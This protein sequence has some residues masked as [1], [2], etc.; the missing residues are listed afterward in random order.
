MDYQIQIKELL[1]RLHLQLKFAVTLQP[2]IQLLNNLILQT[3]DFLDLF[4]QSNSMK[5]ITQYL[6]DALKSIQPNEEL[7]YKILT[8]ILRMN[9]SE[10]I[11]RESEIAK[12]LLKIK[13]KK[14]FD[15]IRSNMIEQ[16]QQQWSRCYI[17]FKPLLEEWKRN[18]NQKDK[19][20]DR[21]KKGKRNQSSSSSE[22]SNKKKKN[23]K[24]FVRFQRDE[25]L[26]N[27]KYFK[28]DDEPNQ[29]GM[30]LEEVAQFQKQYAGEL[31]RFNQINGAY[32]IKH[33]ES[34]M[35]GQ[36]HKLQQDNIQQM[37]EQIPFIKPAKLFLQSQ[38]NYDTNYI[39]TAVQQKRTESKMS[40]FYNR[41]S[42]PDQPG[43]NE[44]S[45]TQSGMQPKSIH[46]DPPKREDLIYM[47][48]IICSRGLK[49][50][51][52]KNK[53]ANKKQVKGILKK[54]PDEQMKQKDVLNQAKQDL[55]PKMQQLVQMVEQKH[56]HS[57]ETILTLLHDI[58]QKLKD[59]GEE[60]Y[61]KN[62][63][64]ILEVKLN[65]KQ[66]I[67][68]E[69]D[70]VKA[71]QDQQRLRLEQL[72]TINPVQALRLRAYKTKHCH[73]FHS[74]LG[75]TRGDNC[76]FIHDSRYPGRTA[77]TL[78]YPNFLNKTLYPQSSMAIIVPPLLQQLNPE[79]LLGRQKKYESL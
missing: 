49:E 55:Q 34:L 52:E 18:N 48:S 23:K 31:R 69:V 20:E 12:P 28:R 17:K 74:S 45:N 50:I 3:N 22:S 16:L 44:I 40:A 59:I 77:P 13:D 62:F 78:Q 32:N 9:L 43:Y 67:M 64:S 7:I 36:E 2:K 42:I 72:Q 21:K 51:E 65:D 1:K 37:L 54:P 27:F 68:S 19:Q 70:R 79:I 39:E 15:N 41:D 38:I 71:Q 25:L 63:K 60:K 29:R 35:E 14:L 66:T 5:I 61:I 4:A 10:E 11:V 8:L 6:K 53:N 47:V 26:L 46:L 56:Q 57:Q 24:K 33:R 58:I 73:N 76:N 30:T 75:C